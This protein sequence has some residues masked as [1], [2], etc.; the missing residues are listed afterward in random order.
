MQ[1]GQGS[2]PTG[3]RKVSDWARLL[4]CSE[5]KKPLGDCELGDY[6]CAR[7]LREME[8]AASESNGEDPMM[9]EDD[10]E[11]VTILES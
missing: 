9:D 3:S 7:L 11:L 5:E 1:A 4:Q 6:S 8:T 2:I 10:N